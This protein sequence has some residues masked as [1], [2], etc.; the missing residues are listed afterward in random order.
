[1]RVLRHYPLGRLLAF[2]YLLGVHLFIYIL[3]HR[4]QRRAFAEHDRTFSADALAR[5]Q[6]I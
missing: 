2:A 1:M 3:I 5:D 4:L 6:R